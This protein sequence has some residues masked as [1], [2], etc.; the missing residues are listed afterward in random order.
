MKSALFVADSVIDL[1]P[2]GTS[3]SES[4]LLGLFTDFVI[5]HRKP[6]TE[7]DFV[8]AVEGGPTKTVLF[9]RSGEWGSG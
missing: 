5:V 9:G 7:N 2:V 3:E 1:D 6:S 4:E 8:E